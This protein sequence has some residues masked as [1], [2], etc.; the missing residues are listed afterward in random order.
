MNNEIIITAKSLKPSLE[1]PM[2]VHQDHYRF[3]N[4]PVCAAL[5]YVFPFDVF[6]TS[7]FCLCKRD[8]IIYRHKCFS[9]SPYTVNGK[10]NIFSL[11]GVIWSYS[12]LEKWNKNMVMLQ[13]HATHNLILIFMHKLYSNFPLKSDLGWID[14]IETGLSGT[15]NRDYLILLLK[16]PSQWEGITLHYPFHLQGKKFPGRPYCAIL[17]SRTQ[18]TYLGG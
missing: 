7:H 10:N 16:I 17:G 14:A 1:C 13:I 6:T 11:R 2:S 12:L 4:L 18:S 8:L 5:N 9:F 3:W 15:P